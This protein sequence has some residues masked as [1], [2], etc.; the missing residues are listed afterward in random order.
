MDTRYPEL[1]P[2]RIEGTEGL[3]AN[4]LHGG[5]RE[6]TEWKPQKPSRRGPKDSGKVTTQDVEEHDRWALGPKAHENV[7]EK[8]VG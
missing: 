5:T 6:T 4:N 7:L 8:R 1:L 2:R 3:Q